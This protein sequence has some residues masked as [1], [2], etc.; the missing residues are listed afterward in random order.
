MKILLSGI[1]LILGLVMVP[2]NVSA[3]DDEP[4]TI[5]ECPS[6]DKYL[7]Y[8]NADGLRVRKGK[9]KTTVSVSP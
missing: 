9:G 4:T 1:C 8:T 3:I 5:V 7:C 6:G 2:Q